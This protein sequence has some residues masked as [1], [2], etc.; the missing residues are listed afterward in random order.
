MSKIRAM[1]EAI[2]GLEFGSD[3]LAAART[4]A[5]ERFGNASSD[6]EQVSEFLHALSAVRGVDPSTVFALVG[7]RL[8]AP[9]LVEFPAIAKNQPTAMS[10]LLSV[11]RSLPKAL[12]ALMSIEDEPVLDV[13]LLEPDLLRLRFTGPPELASLMEGLS[14]GLVEHF[15]ERVTV[16]HVAPPTGTPNVRTLEMR[17][18]AERRG[19]GDRR[20]E[21]AN[22]RGPRDETPPG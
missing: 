11:S 5:N 12:G 6:V 19:T 1:M 22:R 21:N 9:V 2:V 10:V 16:V 8:V 3:D 4:L 13:E 7:R 18:S 17:I 15:G 20:K 14:I